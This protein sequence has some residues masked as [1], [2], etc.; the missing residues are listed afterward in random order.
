MDTETGKI[1]QLTEEELNRLNRGIG[2]EKFIRMKVSPTKVQ[3]LRRPPKV[4][5]NEPCPCGSGKKFKRCH[6]RARTPLEQERK[7]A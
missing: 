6:L 3:M 5:R 7:G 2:Y 1:V 4:G